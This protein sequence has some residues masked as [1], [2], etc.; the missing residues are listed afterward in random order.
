[1]LLVASRSLK[2]WLAALNL[3]VLVVGTLR[4]PN[5]AQTLGIVPANYLRAATETDLKNLNALY[6]SS[7]KS[8][9]AVFK[10]YIFTYMIMFC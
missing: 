1:M 3:T 6:E 9:A 7:N 5:A 4:A 2:D 8:P 10:A